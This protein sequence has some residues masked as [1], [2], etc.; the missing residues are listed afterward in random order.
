MSAPE[1]TIIT[2][3][4]NARPWL[5]G[6]LACTREQT[7][8]HFEHIIIDDC[9]S[10]GSLEEAQRLAATDPRI[11]V[12]RAPKNGGPA[13]ARNLGI[14][15]SKGRFLAF[16][17]ADDLWLPNKL[18][19]QLAWMKQTGHAFTYHDYRHISHDGTKVGKLISG[20]DSMDL[21][22]LH[23]RRKGTCGCLS[24]MIDRQQ[25]PNF[26]FPDI[27]RALPE[28]FLAWLEVLKQGHIAYRLGED[29][30]RYRLVPSSRS[31]NKLGAAMAVWN[32]YYRV[33]GLPL[34]KAA[35]WWLQ[36]AWNTKRLHRESS[37][38]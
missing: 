2:P 20:T 14:A 25:I 34:P 7:F 3:M 11:K 29:L 13:A 28:D 26:K 18:E 4:Y 36:Y 22:A 24:V 17:D 19:R 30:A 16:L 10:D 12:L 5:E 32:L 38:E 1:V 35:W 37:P 15:Q 9:S 21:R 6:L 31:A 27:E 8:P 23:V 33:E